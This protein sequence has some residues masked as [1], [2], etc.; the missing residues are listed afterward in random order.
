MTITRAGRD[1]SLH[2]QPRLGGC[3]ANEMSQIALERV[4]GFALSV[5]P[6]RTV[7]RT[8]QS[9]W[10]PDLLVLEASEQFLH[11]VLRYLTCRLDFA[12]RAL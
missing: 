10:S 9:L 6:W 12:F 2:K 11:H 7:V 8:R 1:L 4:V 5:S 3:I